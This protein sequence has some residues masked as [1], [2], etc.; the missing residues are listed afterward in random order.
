MK[1]FLIGLILFTI[2]CN[3]DELQKVLSLGNEADIECYSGGKL[4]YKG[5]STGKVSSAE[6]SDGYFFK[7]KG[8]GLL[9]EVSGN[10]V[11]TYQ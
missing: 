1:Y 8:S 6:N 2:G 4:I 10:C 11:I 3:D 9:K 7:E 5:T